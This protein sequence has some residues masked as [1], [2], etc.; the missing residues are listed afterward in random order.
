MFGKAGELM[1]KLQEMKRKADEIKEKLSLQTVRE[2]G[3]GG[4]IVVEITGERRIRKIVIAPGLQHGGNAELT[5]QL[6]SVLNRAIEKADR[7]N[8][9][10]M[11]KAAS[12][13]LPGMF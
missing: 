10:E 7:L 5:E 1:G 4:D 3:A 13:M 2:E 8:E 6:E 9:E 11:K 12:G